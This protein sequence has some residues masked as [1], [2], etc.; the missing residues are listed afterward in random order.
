MKFFCFVI[1]SLFAN[2]TA[3][4]SSENRGY[5]GAG[6]FAMNPY[7]TAATSS[8]TISPLGRIFIPITVAY[9]TEMWM[10]TLRFSPL[11][12]SDKD[13]SSSNRILELAFP[14]L[15][16]G[17][18]KVGPGIFGYWMSGGSGTTVLNN[19]SSTSTFYRPG[20]SSFAT[21]WS[22][23]LGTGADLGAARWD[24]DLVLISALSARRS[25]NLASTLSFPLF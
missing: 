14:F 17:S 2:T 12:V 10:P 7:K 20:R 3:W 25:F 9:K 8:G 15:L 18:L 22:V 1:I 19:G 6:V 21:H 11:A 13:T 5:V 23:V 16:G 24:L 4:S